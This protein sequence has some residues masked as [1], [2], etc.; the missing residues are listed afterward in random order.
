MT[1]LHGDL[2]DVDRRVDF[3]PLGFEQGNT[4]ISCTFQNSCAG[5]REWIGGLQND[6]GGFMKRLLL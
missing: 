6:V 4:M 1:Q 3:G 2:K 5:R